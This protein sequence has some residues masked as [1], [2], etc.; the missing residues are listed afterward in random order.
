MLLFFTLCLCRVRLSFGV[1]LPMCLILFNPHI[2]FSI[3]RPSPSR[4]SSTPH[5]NRSIISTCLFA[6]FPRSSILLLLVVH[7]FHSQS[8]LLH[9]TLCPMNILALFWI[10]SVC[11]RLWT[12]I[13]ALL[14]CYKPHTIISSE[15]SA[16]AL[17]FYILCISVP[18]PFIPRV[19]SHFIAHLWKH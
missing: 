10:S 9:S 4:G 16:A 18:L 13:G 5:F 14:F 19:R 2:L 15:Y 17:I 8:F 3:R 6:F 12:G 1:S 7:M 11:P